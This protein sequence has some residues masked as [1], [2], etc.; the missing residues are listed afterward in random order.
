M[1]EPNYLF[2]K[3]DW[4]KV[5]DNQKQQLIAEVAKMDGSRLLNTSTDDLF[6]YFAENYS[7]NVPTLYEKRIIADQKETQIDGSGDRL[8]AIADALYNHDPRSRKM[9]R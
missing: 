7:F 2:S 3:Y 5:Q 1:R 6:D 9:H 8:R 4:R